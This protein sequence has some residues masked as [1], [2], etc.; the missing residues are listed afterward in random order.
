MAWRLPSDGLLHAWR[1]FSPG[2]FHNFF[3]G[4]LSA[5]VLLFRDIFARGI[6]RLW[7]DVSEGS[8]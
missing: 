8:R 3:R 1:V 7:V 2:H 5:S 6:M 4:E